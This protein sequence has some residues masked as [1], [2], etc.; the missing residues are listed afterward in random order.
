M[1]IIFALWFIIGKLGLVLWQLSWLSCNPKRIRNLLGS[2]D[3][4]GT[5]V[6]RGFHLFF[7]CS[8]NLPCQSEFSVSLNISGA[9]KTHPFRTP[10]TLSQWLSVLRKPI[11]QGWR[12]A[13]SSRLQC[14][15]PNKMNLKGNSS[16]PTLSNVPDPSLLAFRIYLL[17][18]YLNK[19]LVFRCV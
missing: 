11:S 6:P 5:G 14:N 19:W 3:L 1:T 17:L 9:W 2:W 15:P 16:H 8:S 4:K 12:C 7:Q 10:A 13:F 18:F